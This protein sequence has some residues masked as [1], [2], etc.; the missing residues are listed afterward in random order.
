MYIISITVHEGIPADK[1]QEMLTRHRDWFTNYF[2]QGIFLM[3][4]PYI[5]TSAHAGVI[6]AHT[7]SREA[8]QKILEED[9]YY[10]DFAD[11]DIREFAPKMIADDIGKAIIP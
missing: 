6:F 5:D 8:L 2:R 1:Q 11:Y 3:L 10:P 9:S 4:G 7:D